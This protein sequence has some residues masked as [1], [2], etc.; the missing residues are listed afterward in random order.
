MLTVIFHPN[1]LHFRKGRK[2]IRLLFGSAKACELDLESSEL[3]GGQI[4]N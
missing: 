3:V 4:V 2:K 1:Q